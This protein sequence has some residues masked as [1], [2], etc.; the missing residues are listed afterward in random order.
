MGAI[1]YSSKYIDNLSAQTDSLRK[2]LNKDN[3]CLCTEEHT[4]AF[5][6]L[7]EKDHGDTM[8]GSL[9]LKLS[10]RDN[11]RRQYESLGATLLQE[12]PD[13]KLNKIGFACRFLS[14]T[15][16]IRDKRT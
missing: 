4:Q 8:S 6:N 10:E 13:G 11:N 3:E 1:H 16:K 14:D 7:K 9:Q 15:K 2:F 5:E 12:Q